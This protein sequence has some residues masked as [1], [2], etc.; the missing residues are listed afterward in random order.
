MQHPWDPAFYN[1]P[2]I[3]RPK[4]YWEWDFLGNKELTIQITH[5]VHPIKRFVT[6][7]FFGSKWKKVDNK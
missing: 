2:A 3:A 1:A 7:I 4:V 6:R 5:K